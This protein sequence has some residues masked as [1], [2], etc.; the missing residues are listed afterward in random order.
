MARAIRIDMIPRTPMTADEFAQRI[1]HT[2]LK[3]EASAA[4][5]M[6]VAT[7]A[8]QNRFA[9]VCVAPRWVERVAMTLK[10]SNAPVCAVAGFPHGTNKS[11][12]KAIEASIA[13][14]DGA[15]EVDVV[16]FLPHLLNEDLDA[17]RAE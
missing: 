6:R 7:E 15:A 11:T 1:D 8:V 16:A 3:P 13:V 17:A 2:I 14:K 12:M 4:A 5:V 9:R 10:G